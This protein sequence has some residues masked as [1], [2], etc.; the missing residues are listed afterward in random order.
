MSLLGAKSAGDPTPRPPQATGVLLST[1]LRHH[2]LLPSRSRQSS[3]MHSLTPPPLTSADI[4]L[5]RAVTTAT[6][7][8]IRSLLLFLA[9]WTLPFASSRATA[10]P[11]AHVSTGSPSW[12]TFPS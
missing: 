1:L 6:I 12:T 7:G 2:H 10:F 8:S 4:A 3:S 5:A 11:T 9:S